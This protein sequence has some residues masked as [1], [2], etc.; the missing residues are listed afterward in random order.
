MDTDDDIYTIYKR[1]KDYVQK[2]EKDEYETCIK[3]VRSIE[4]LLNLSLLLSLSRIQ[5]V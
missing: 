3:Q 1:S 2:L 5:H 4:N